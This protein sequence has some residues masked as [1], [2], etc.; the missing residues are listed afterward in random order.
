VLS[1][2][3]LIE[4]HFRLP[5]GILCEGAL[6]DVRK[7]D[8]LDPKIVQQVADEMAKKI[9]QA[10]LMAGRVLSG[11]GGGSSTSSNRLVESPR[12]V[13]RKAP[14]KME[15]DTKPAPGWIEMCRGGDT[16]VTGCKNCGVVMFMRTTG[17]N[18][19]LI[20]HTY[21]WWRNQHIKYGTDWAKERMLDYIRDEHQG[22]LDP[23]WT[24]E[25]KPL[26]WERKE[27]VKVPSAV[28]VLSLVWIA[29]AGVDLGLF[30]STGK[31]LYL[32]CVTM[33]IIAIS[34]NQ[35]RQRQKRR[36]AIAENKTRMI[37][38]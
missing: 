19:H 34:A 18:E 32:F 20:T 16:P 29:L 37:T 23:E 8:V 28:P 3:W 6:A 33:Y 9:Q 38:R 35:V 11:G 4:R 26:P 31:I 15:A 22:V 12:R 30:A 1:N 24:G 27:P 14:K 17:Q 5:S 13:A 36:K 25:E 2:G 10:V 21:E 7:K